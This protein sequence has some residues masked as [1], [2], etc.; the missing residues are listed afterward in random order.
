[1]PGRAAPALDRWLDIQK[2]DEERQGEKWSNDLGLFFTNE[3]GGRLNA[4]HVLHSFQRVLAGAGLG[5]K[6]FYDLRQAPTWTPRAISTAE[7]KRSS[8]GPTCR[9]SRAA[10]TYFLAPRTGSKTLDERRLRL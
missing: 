9:C 7:P 2:A 8:A 4:T 5:R 10:R 3:T 6:R 1:M